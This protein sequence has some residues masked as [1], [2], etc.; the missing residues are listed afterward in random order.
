MLL[1]E[2]STELST[3]RLTEPHTEHLVESITKSH[4]LP[5][6]ELHTESLTESLTERIA[7]I[8]P[9]ILADSADRVVSFN[10]A[11]GRYL[12]LLV[13][14]FVDP[15]TN[16]VTNPE[17]LSRFVNKTKSFLGDLGL[18]TLPTTLVV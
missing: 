8:T 7:A 16:R 3:K 10:D 17:G 15:D 6:I 2:S 14:N 11:A 12:R 4:T 5:S 18:P 9:K 1:T 13:N